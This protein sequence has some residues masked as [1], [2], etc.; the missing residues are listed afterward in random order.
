MN[1]KGQATLFIILGIVIV[2]LISLGVFYRGQIQSLVSGG[3]EAIPLGDDEDDI[4]NFIQVCLEDSV[5]NGLFLAQ[6]QSGRVFLTRTGLAFEGFLVPYVYDQGDFLVPSKQELEQQFNFYVGQELYKC[7]NA[8]SAEFE[9]VQSRVIIAQNVIAVDVIFPFVT[10]AGESTLRNDRPYS[11]SIE[12]NILSFVSLM[13]DV[14]SALSREPEGIPVGLFLTQDTF[15]VDTVVLGDE[16]LYSLE[17]ENN[18]AELYF[19]STR[20]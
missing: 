2:L 18:P 13:R 8:V 5:Q 20:T 9:A 16:T 10:Y 14:S 1:K 3:S 12:S 17:S 6:K 7:A 11:Y 4:R 19:F 15:K